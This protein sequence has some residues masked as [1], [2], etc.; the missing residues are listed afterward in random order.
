MLPPRI[1]EPPPHTP[2]HNRHPEPDTHKIPESRL[3][4]TLTLTTPGVGQAS[5]VAET[6]RRQPAGQCA[7]IRARR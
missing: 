2:H 3:P 4:H 7:L 5:R 6:R 1:E